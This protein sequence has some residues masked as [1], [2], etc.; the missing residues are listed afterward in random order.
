MPASMQRRMQNKKRTKRWLLHGNGYL[1]NNKKFYRKDPS[2]S[3]YVLFLILITDQESIQ[4]LYFLY[5]D[6]M[7]NDLVKCSTKNITCRQYVHSK[8]FHVKKRLTLAKICSTPVSMFPCIYV[9]LLL[10]FE[11][12]EE[13]SHTDVWTIVNGRLNLARLWETDWCRLKTRL[14]S[15]REQ[16]T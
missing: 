4:N 15:S 7:S 13:T 5:G 2:K 9:M 1:Q 10:N 8:E 11:F 12:A 14:T 6:W 3:M 16:R